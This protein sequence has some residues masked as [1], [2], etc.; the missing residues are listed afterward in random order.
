[1]NPA[2]LYAGIGRPRPQLFGKGA[3]YKTQDGGAHW[4]QVNTPGSLPAD[5]LVTDVVIDLRDNRRLF[6]A[7][8]YGLYRSD[9]AGVSWVLTIA[10]LPHPHVRRIAQ[11][12]SQPDILYL[13]LWSPPGVPPWQGGVY[14]STD[15]GKFWSACTQGLARQVGQPGQASQMTANYDRLVVHPDNPNV[16]YVGGT[17]WVNATI[18]KTTDGGKTWTSVVRRGTGG[19]TED[20]WITFW[21]AD[22]QSPQHVA[23]RS[24]DA[25]LRDLGQGLQDFR[26]GR[27]LAAD[28][29]ADAG[30]MGG[31]RGS[32]WRRPACSTWSSTP[33]T[34]NV[35][36]SAT[37]TSAC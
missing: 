8:Q 26:R 2:V 19:N 15:G 5:A 4:K 32:V 22:V 23:V 35:S 6:L 29:H 14:K 28:L 12:R 37:G 18:Y 27:A 34:P 24:R 31:T 20:G 13:T 7:C 30:R 21:G 1:M 33:P 9:D 17:G 11:C 25:L 16:V 36:I 10:G 3:V